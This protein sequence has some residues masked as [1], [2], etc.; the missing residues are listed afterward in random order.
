MKLKFLKENKNNG[1]MRFLKVI[2]E[3]SSWLNILIIFESKTNYGINISLLY[4]HWAFG[5]KVIIFEW[6][7]SYSN[8][9]AEGIEHKN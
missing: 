7:K 1:R 4:K 6:K 9:T 5:Y 8:K 2:K 3:K